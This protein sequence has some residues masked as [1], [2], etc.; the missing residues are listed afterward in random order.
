MIETR[1][2]PK[3]VDVFGKAKVGENE[4]I[5]LEVLG[6][7]VLGYFPGKPDGEEAWIDAIYDLENQEMVSTKVASDNNYLDRFKGAA[8]N[9]GEGYR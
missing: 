7:F 9:L 3:G 8:K 2:P 5:Q 1:K 4:E 6:Q